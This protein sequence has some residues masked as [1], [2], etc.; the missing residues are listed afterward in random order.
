MSKIAI[1]HEVI[2]EA[3]V[4]SKKVYEGKLRHGEGKKILSAGNRMS[5]SSAGDYINNFRYFLNGS[6]ITRALNAPSIDYFISQIHQDYGRSVLKK[7]LASLRDHIVYFEGVQKSKTTLH[8]LR[9]ILAKHEEKLLNPVFVRNLDQ[10][11]ENI[12]YLELMLSEGDE[13]QRKKASNI[14][15][16]GTCFIVYTMNGESRFIPS[17]FVGYEANK[18]FRFSNKDIDGRETT[19]VLN[20]II[21]SKPNPNSELER[22]YINYC[23]SLGIKPQ[24]KGGAYAKTRKYWKLNLIDK[25]LNTEVVRDYAEGSMVERIHRA[26]ERNPIVIQK[27]KAEF[28]TRNGKLFCEVCKFDFEKAYGEIGKDFIE[29]HHTIPVKDMPPEH[30]TKPSDI[31]MLCANCHRMIHASKNWLTLEHLQKLLKRK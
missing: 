21:G 18:L 3:Y 6:K 5:D 28:K 25:R 9:S 1:S 7:A 12:Q 10:V 16:Q 8:K 19:K 23:Q 13:V 14:I 31:A 2:P 29:G 26:R 4:V 17:R 22:G 30:R 15:K 27:A 24:P 20:R 11:F